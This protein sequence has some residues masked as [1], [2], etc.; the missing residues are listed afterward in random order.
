MVSYDR[1][2]Y[3]TVTSISNNSWTIPSNP[4]VD[5][6]KSTNSGYAPAGG[7][8]STL[9][10]TTSSTTARLRNTNT[11]M[12]NIFNDSDFVTGFWFKSVSWKTPDY[13]DGYV[14]QSVGQASATG[15]GYA[16]FYATTPDDLT[17]RFIFEPGGTN[18]NVSNTNINAGDGAWHFLAVRKIGARIIAYVD[19]TQIYDSN[20]YTSGDF[21]Y[22]NNTTNN[23]TSFNVGHT[24]TTNTSSFMISN[25]FTGSSTKFTQAVLTDIYAIGAGI[26]NVSHSATPVTATALMRDPSISASA[27]I[28]ATPLTATCL[29]TSPTIVIVAN[30]HTEI[31]TSITVSTLF[32]NPTVVSSV[33]FSFQMSVLGATVT[34]NSSEVD[35]NTS[36]SFNVNTFN[37]NATI[38]EPVPVA[39]PMSAEAIIPNPRVTAD[40]SYF[41]YVMSSGPHFYSNF[42]SSTLTNYGTLPVSNVFIGSTVTKNVS[43]GGSLG[44]IGGGKSWRFDG[45][46][47]NAPNRIEVTPTESTYLYNLTN[48]SNMSFEFWGKITDPQGQL[49]I[50]IGRYRV[51]LNNYYAE[52]LISNTTNQVYDSIMGKYTYVD[53]DLSSLDFPEP[54]N[55]VKPYDWNHVVV[56]ISGTYPNA[57]L[58]Q[59]YVNGSLALNMRPYSLR[60]YD[61]SYSQYFTIR[62]VGT[63]TEGRIGVPGTYIDEFAIYGRPLLNSEIIDRFSYISTKSPNSQYFSLP[64]VATTA[65]GNHSFVV[66]T[67]VNIPATPIT[68]STVIVQPTV[69]ARKNVNFSSQ[70]LNAGADISS[71]VNIYY[72]RTYV[73]DIAIAYVEIAPGYALDSTYRNYVKTNIDPYRYV[74]FDAQ[75]EFL[76]SGIDA[77]YSVASTVVGGQIVSP[78]F[79]INGKSAKTSGSSYITDGVILK[80]SEWNDSWGTGQNSYHSAFWF[81]RALDDASTTGL[82]V[83][84]NL[85]GYKDNQHVVL[86]QY[87]GKLHMQFNNGSG[88]WIEQDTT[89]NIDLFDYNRH[90][91]VIEFD[92]TNNNNN[93]VRLY[94]DAVL[95]MTVN[96]GTYTGSTTNAAT[97]D[98]GPNDEANNRARLS[99]GCLITPFASTALPV[100]PA[101]TKLIIDEIYWDK[102]SI[103]S[104]MVTNLY[105][106]MPTNIDINFVATPIEAGALIVN[107]SKSIEIKKAAP[108]LTASLDIVSPV[109]RVVFNLIIVVTPLTA[110]ATTVNAQRIDNV[111]INS[112]V[113]MISASLNGGEVKITISGGD[114]NISAK[115]GQGIVIVVNTYRHNVNESL[116]LWAKYLRYDDPWRFRNPLTFMEEIK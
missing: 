115:M 61:V 6:L 96:L 38:V 87:Q 86:Y 50:D 73:A 10:T 91:V 83:L 111:N 42:D 105:N 84:W 18:L 7:D 27:I 82:R 70:S 108:T 106:I 58:M 69:L 109:I 36:T 68:S 9:F 37:A 46:Y 33:N 43:S 59:I 55:L 47:Y 93:I 85:N 49:Q 64:C 3:S 57:T 66:E 81:K 94:V 112:D 2:G 71:G 67:K 52:A 23:A 16:W 13:D 77:D 20:N 12:L 34:F 100:V 74:A 78:S 54:A 44:L 45:N 25:F 30:N 56:N 29:A 51:Y 116:S 19:M 114:I 63:G 5:R 110:N 24:D 88:T 35:T 53:G 76:D 15:G 92:H 11:A 28:T 31:T 60:P 48:S 62:S 104:T 95:K 107:P 1:F 32:V 17:P 21:L 98:S 75:D 90:F 102:N 14:I 97:A 99:I 8:R 41:S 4:S 101:N 26:T 80:E 79:G 113:F 65:T 89:S 40:T 103:T 72:G 39:W 22:S